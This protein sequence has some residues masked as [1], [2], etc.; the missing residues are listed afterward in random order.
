MD[1]NALELEIYNATRKAFEDLRR[2]HSNEEFY[3]YALYTDSDAMTVQ[4][5]ANSLHGFEKA[6]SHQSD[7]SA[8]T[9]AYYKWATSEWAYEG[10]KA[11]F[12]KE[13]SAQLRTSESRKSLATFKQNVSAAMTG[14]LKK[15][16]AEGFFGVNAEREEVVLFISVTDDDQAQSVED[17]SARLLNPR[18][19][20][21]RFARRYAGDHWPQ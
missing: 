20:S 4:A 2:E 21:E 11:S 5:S 13:I 6:V 7:T 9:L 15:L 8:A 10:W 19:V 1:W 16:D 17:D 3:A 12:F 18:S 14:A